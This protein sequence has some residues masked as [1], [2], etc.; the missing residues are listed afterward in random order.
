[1]T[2]CTLPTRS[3]TSRTS[4]AG[5]NRSAY[6]SRSWAGRFIEKLKARALRPAPFLFQ[7]ANL[8]PVEA[9]FLDLAVGAH[10]PAGFGRSKRHS[11]NAGY[12]RNGEPGFSLIRSPCRTA[13]VGPDH[14]RMI[15]A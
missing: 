11:P 5:L 4:I 15:V 13:V 10:Q 7:S 3:S 12:V 14:H 8:V 9:D 2:I 1:M 6:S